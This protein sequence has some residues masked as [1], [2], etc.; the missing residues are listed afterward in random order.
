MTPEQVQ[1]LYQASLSPLLSPQQR[2]SIQLEN[3]YGFKGKVAEILQGE[4]AKLAPL[5]AREWRDAA[6]CTMSLEAAAAMQGLAP[7]TPE[8]ELELARMNPQ[9]EAEQTQM[10][11]D[12]I[13]SQG[14]PY[15]SPAR[16]VQGPNGEDVLIPEGEKNLTN[17]LILQGI[18][19]DIAA[20]CK[21]EA[22]PAAPTHSFTPSEIAGMARLGYHPAS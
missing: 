4:V 12:Q 15:G 22:M 16:Y 21:A 5:L 3:P 6:G 20:Q 9:T 17:Q 19:P 13:L 1:V 18:A 10:Q 2:A 8:I 11:V 14:N 7:S